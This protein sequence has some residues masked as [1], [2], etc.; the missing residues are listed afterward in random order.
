[1][2]Q[3]LSSWLLFLIFILQDLEDK[4]LRGAL[5][6]LLF[7]YLDALQALLASVFIPQPDPPW[8]P[9]SLPCLLYF[10]TLHV[11]VTC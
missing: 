1:V 2:S 7:F 3:P 6:N 5:E 8:Y 9:L 10:N 11:C 4:Q